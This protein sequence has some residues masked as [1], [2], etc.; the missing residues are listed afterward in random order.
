VCSATLVALHDLTCLS[1][2]RRV[3]YATGTNNDSSADAKIFPCSC[4]DCLSTVPWSCFSFAQA[5]PTAVSRRQAAPRTGHRLDPPTRCVAAACPPTTLKLTATA[6]VRVVVFST[7]S[8]LPPSFCQFRTDC[9]SANAG[10]VVLVV[11]LSWAFVLVT[12]ALAQETNGLTKSECSCLRV[13]S[14]SYSPFAACVA[15]FLFWVQTLMIML[16]GAHS[17]F[18][19]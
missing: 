17:A 1:F 13:L 3:Y 12:H 6:S 9:P 11:L 15:V 18:G 16:S 8:F 5:H 14:S 2:W 7:G 4:M 19:W 10:L